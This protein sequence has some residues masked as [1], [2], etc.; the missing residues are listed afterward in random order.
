MVETEK[1]ITEKSEIDNPNSN[2]VPTVSETA[3]L[4]RFIFSIFPITIIIFHSKYKRSLPSLEEILFNRIT[5]SLKNQMKATFRE[6]NII[7]SMLIIEISS[8]LI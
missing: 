2:N 6:Y 3:L 5:M 1:Y 8:Q 4:A 7:P